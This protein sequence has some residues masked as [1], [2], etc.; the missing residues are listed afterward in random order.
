MLNSELI[1]TAAASIQ[2]AR[3]EAL[4]CAA[5]ERW[6][7]LTKPPGSLGMLEEVVVRYALAAGRLP[8]RESLRKAMY[9]FCGDHGVTAEGVSPYP[10]EVTAQMVKNFVRGGA[11]INV[12]C[13]QFGIEAVIVDAGVKGPAERGVVDRKIAEG[14]RNFARGPAMSREEAVRAVESGI[15]LAREAAANCDLAGAG[16]MGIGNTTAAGALLCVFG[17]V[18]P[19]EAAGRGTGLDDAGVARKAA[20]LR[21]A[22]EVNR[23]DAA[24]PVGALAAVGGLEIAMMTGFLIG[25]AASRLPVVVDG[26]ISCSAALAA[27]AIAPEAADYL[28]Y[29]H[30]SAERGHRRMLEALGARPLLS[31]DM[32]LGEGSGAALGMALVESG[33]RLFTGMATFA[34]ARVSRDERR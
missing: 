18:P 3:D 11:A 12:L 15:E 9:I 25:G 26:F 13:R 21:R 23:P 34:E 20:V 19:E 22:L 28:L 33:V 4:E 24:D 27:R 8:A 6:D 29:S 17:G 1:R 2:P 14:T 7:S 5:R 16:E 10:S 30:R 32:R 31:L